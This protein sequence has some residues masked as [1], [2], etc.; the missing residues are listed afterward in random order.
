MS[1]CSVMVS[2]SDP[3]LESINDTAVRMVINCNTTYL[4]KDDVRLNVS[5]GMKNLSASISCS[6]DHDQS[7]YIQGLTCGHEYLMSVFWYHSDA[8]QYNLHPCVLAQNI[9]YTHKHKKCSG[10]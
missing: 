3:V 6:K 5:L 7:T 10:I 4:N 9:S 1:I 2:T 8:S